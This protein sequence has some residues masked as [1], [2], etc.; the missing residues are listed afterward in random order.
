[1][2]RSI[3]A[4]TAL[5]AWAMG[6]HDARAQSMCAT[7]IG[8]C[9]VNGIGPPGGACFCFSPA[10]PVQGIIP[11]ATPVPQV[12]DPFPH[13]CCTPAGR[14]GPYPN[15]SIQAGQ[16]CQAMLPNGVPMTGQACY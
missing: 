7:S 1:M 9:V 4:V 15:V 16:F 10:G 12:G 11:G 6:V 5:V 2:K 8:T 3:V 13:F 14:I